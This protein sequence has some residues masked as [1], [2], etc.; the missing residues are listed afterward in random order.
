[1]SCIRLAAKTLLVFLAANSLRAATNDFRCQMITLPVNASASLFADFDNDGLSDLFAVDPVNNQLLIYRQ[2]PSGFTNEPHQ[3]IGLPQQT[4]WISLCDV[5]AHPRLE[6]LMSTAAGLLYYRQNG[7]V[8]E[9]EQ[10]TLVK[11]GQVFTNDGSPALI[12]LATNAAI[13]VISATSAVLYQ[14]TN[15]FEWIPGQPNAFEVKRTSWHADRSEWTIGPNSAR[16]MYLQQSL[17][18]KPDDAENW[19]PENDTIRKLTD[20]M[21]NAAVRDMLGT[22]HVDVNGDGR[23]D[24][25]L[26]QTFTGID[27]RTDVHIFLRGADGKLGDQPTQALHCRG[28]P[29]PVGSTEQGS[30]IG[31]LKGDGTY[32]LVLVE[33]KTA[34]TS[35]DSLVEMALSG[36][37]E[38]ALTIRTFNNG[39]FSGSPNATIPIRTIMPITTL[40]PVEEFNHWP[41]FICGDFNG[42]GRPDLLVRQSTTR[43]SILFSTADDRWF[44]PQPAMT[45]ETPI[46]GYFDIKDLNG[47]GRSDIVLR[48]QNDPRIFICLSPSQQAKGNHP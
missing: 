44:M 27:P 35:V 8:F 3:V 42:D 17:R 29:I 25:I 48:A 41:F 23:K 13:P 22:N 6:L 1:M 4:A 32:Q 15:G 34:F 43:W 19:K 46:Q 40:V 28:F 18:S 33:L 36:G 21:K 9:T 38:C 5:D 45:F 14:R 7:G 31:D 37:L 26:W 12:S 16:S 24:L 30:P 10:R 47:D 11:A 20:E 39:A 2:R